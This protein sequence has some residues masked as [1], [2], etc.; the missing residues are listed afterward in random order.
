YG[1]ELGVQN[2]ILIQQLLPQERKFI[3]E[4]SLLFASTCKSAFTIEHARNGEHK[5]SSLLVAEASTLVN[6]SLGALLEKPKATSVRIEFKSIHE[7]L[8]RNKYLGIRSVY[9]AKPDYVRREYSGLILLIK[10][11]EQRFK[12]RPRAEQ[13]VAFNFAQAMVRDA[14]TLLPQP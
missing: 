11:I 12:D 2:N 7:T 4:T 8:E 10:K 14:T 5:G 3:E 9:D 13:Q 6:K 1:Y